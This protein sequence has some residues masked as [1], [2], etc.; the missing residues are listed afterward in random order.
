MN[1][2]ISP[3]SSNEIHFNG[4]FKA[5]ISTLNSPPP[6]DGNPLFRNSNSHSIPQCLFKNGKSAEAESEL[7]CFRRLETNS[8][9]LQEITQ[10]QLPQRPG[11]PA[12]HLEL[13]RLLLEQGQTEEGLY[14]L[15][16][17][18]QANPANGAAHRALAD[19]FQQIGD[20]ARAAY[21]R[22][23]LPEPS[24]EGKSTP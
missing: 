22:R 2:E 19:F 1:E 11:D 23:F 15:H 8:L 5:L 20:V 6:K 10:R 18:V 12:L 14:W 7:Q 17:V 4:L 24:E 13:G 21:H 16:R 3:L 9:R